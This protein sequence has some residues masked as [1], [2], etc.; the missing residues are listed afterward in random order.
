[1]T[2]H[3]EVDITNFRVLNQIKSGY[4]S[5]FYL[6]QD[7]NTNKNY[8]AQ[9]IKSSDLDRDTIIR[10]IN[11]MI[12]I[13]HPT[14]I[15]TYFY[16]I[17]DF[18]GDDNYTLIKQ[19]I[20]Y[21]SLNE[22][23]SKNKQGVSN[24]NYNNTTRQKILIGIAQG[25]IYLH[26]HH[27]I[28]CDLRPENI[29]LDDNLEAHITNFAL[30]KLVSSDNQINFTDEFNYK[31]PEVINND[32]Y[33]YKSDIYSFGVLMYE[34]VTDSYPYPDFLQNKITL[35]QLKSKIIDEN[36]RPK[37]TVPVKPKIRELIEQ[38]WANDPN[39]RPT[40][41]E[42]YNKLS[43]D[44]KSP[45]TEISQYL[46][47][48]ID[49]DQI[50][51]YINKIEK[52]D[53]N[54]L[55]SDQD[56]ENDQT[57]PK[58]VTHKTE[59][60]SNLIEQSSKITAKEVNQI[61]IHVK[62]IEA[63]GL[64]SN[65]TKLNPLITIHLKSQPE[66]SEESTDFKSNTTNPIWNEEFDLF[67]T[68]KNDFLIINMLNSIESEYDDD[69]SDDDCYEK[70]IDE[71]HYPLN[72]LIIDGPSIK[73]EIEIS[74]NNSNVGKLYFEVQSFKTEIEPFCT[75]SATG[76]KYIKQKLYA[77][78]TCNIVPENDMGICEVCARNCHKGHDIRFD[79][80]Q[81]LFYCDCHSKFNCCCMPKNK[82]LQCTLIENNRNPIN[83]PMFYCKE[84]DR[85]CKFFICQNCAAKFH[86]GHDLIYLGIV[87]AK[88]CQNDQ[89][90]NNDI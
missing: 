59:D 29:L 62:I 75:F 61:R 77:C 4:L 35:S 48:N 18:N 76:E 39:D 58:T 28:H 20:P 21:G 43:Q 15:K 25:M 16:S 86:H 23:L 90:N 83:Q 42:I 60:Q 14:I 13:K 27:T 3:F 2:H 31:A 78:M 26:Q 82:N 38:C 55:K 63:K 80:V 50:L 52:D 46:L 79:S 5:S 85:S 64:I 41:E 51:L 69:E 24:Q 45:T 11:T 56:N 1:M 49:K 6:V 87:E 67:T 44:I 30:S 70:L 19:Y 71:V 12:R 65:N 32:E 66:Q 73:E 84:C 47:D 10:E 54:S 8:T 81:P 17:T 36:Y 88:I 89:I 33:T 53:T 57:K 40:F 22:L 72:S 7:I 9:I 74:L 68:D 37:F 34:V